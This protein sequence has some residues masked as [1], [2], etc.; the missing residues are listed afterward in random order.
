[1]ML[2][3]LRVRTITSNFGSIRNN[4]QTRRATGGISSTS[5]STSS[6]YSFINKIVLTIVNIVA[7]TVQI[8][9]ARWTVVR[10]A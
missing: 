10:S 9:K 2:I 4:C 5:N 8:T 3:A 7:E 1:M 6:G